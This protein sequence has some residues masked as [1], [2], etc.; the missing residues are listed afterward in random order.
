MWLVA[1]TAAL[2]ALSA[3][4]ATAAAQ[5]GPS[6]EPSYAA[7]RTRAAAERRDVLMVFSHALSPA[8]DGLR[9]DLLA[10]RK[11]QELAD[12]LVLLLCDPYDRGEGASLAVRYNV[13][14][15][16]ALVLVDGA[17]TEV[18]RLEDVLPVRDIRRLLDD[19]LARRGPL[20]R[21][22]QRAR[23]R[24]DD[25]EAALL[26]ARELKSRG[27]VTS[28]RGRLERLAAEPADRVAPSVAA[29]AL[30][31]LALCHLHANDL[32]A[33]QAA[34]AACREREPASAAAIDAE[35]CA[36]RIAAIEGHTADALAALERFRTEHP[37][38]PRASVANDL[39]EKLSRPSP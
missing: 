26:L 28:A 7:A 27:D 37:G 14:R 29:R 34:L 16:P 35:L 31:E 22:R 39:W 20:A 36:A 13:H 9:R 25:L 5:E 38:H 8:S 30:Y 12:R 32:A 24:P 23:E 6:I 19:Y 11:F 10:D 2:L 15:L 33:A 3:L 1:R 18:E 21:L 4:A 17:D